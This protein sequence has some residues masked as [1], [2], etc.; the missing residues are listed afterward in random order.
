MASVSLKNVKK[1]YD[2]NVVAVHDSSLEI[3][4]EE[5]MV[6]LGPSGCGKSTTLRMVA[7]L[8]DISG[9]TIQI[10]DRVIND[11]PPKD[12]DIAM[13]FQNYALYPHMTVFDNMAFGLKLRKV[14]KAEIIE[15]VE[16]VA[17]SLNLGEYLHRK[18]KALSGGQRQR[19]AL[20]RAIVREPTVFLFDEPLSNLDAK[21]RVEMRKELSVL[22]RRLKATIIYVTHDQIEA[23]TLGTRVCVMSHGYIQQVGT[24]L[25]VY[26]F[27]KNIFV[28]KFIGTPAMNILSGELQGELFQEGS[29]DMPSKT[30]T[31]QS[32]NEKGF[33]GIRPEDV[34]VYLDGKGAEGQQ[35]IKAKVEV[36]ERLGDEQ[37]VY[38]NTG[39]NT[40]ICKVD[41]HVPLEYDQDVDF[42]FDLKKCHLFNAEENN[43]TDFELRG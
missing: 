29:F 7:G 33:L 3:H 36:I 12:R 11:V 39:F 4:D 5:F 38:A 40:F 14:P 28:A 30:L 2:D 31:S 37:L 42:V 17:E 8:E 35:K 16:K 21:M 10:G 19:V 22:H 23:M 41:S 27:P 32:F 20:G 24:P 1:V 13:V 15:K 9:G 6:F 25:Q 26:D 34:R 43:V 18:P